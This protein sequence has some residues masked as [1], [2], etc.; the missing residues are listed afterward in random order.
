[1]VLVLNVWIFQTDTFMNFAQSCSKEMFH[2]F[3]GR[4][5]WTSDRLILCTSAWYFVVNSSSIPDWTTAISTSS[6]SASPNFYIMPHLFPTCSITKCPLKSNGSSLEN[7][8]K[9][10][11]RGG[12]LLGT[13]EYVDKHLT[14]KKPCLFKTWPGGKH[15][16]VTP[17]KFVHA[18]QKF[19]T[20]NFFFMQ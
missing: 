15:S 16:R 1:M 7:F 4:L 3:Y 5:T 12:G 19:S 10:I 9:K 18:A 17:R 6:N 2:L 11:S 14:K 20:S 13:R 8:L